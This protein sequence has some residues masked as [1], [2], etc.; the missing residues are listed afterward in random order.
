MARPAAAAAGTVQRSDA[1]CKL[2]VRS[3][4]YNPH[5][6]LGDENYKN[7]EFRADKHLRYKTFHSI[8]NV[9]KITFSF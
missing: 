8:T 9:K 1:N 5:S 3:I 7:L 2:D 6:E 4:L